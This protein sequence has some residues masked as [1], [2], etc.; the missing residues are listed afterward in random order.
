LSKPKFFVGLWTLLSAN[1]AQPD[2]KPTAHA[3]KVK[4]DLIRLI[5]IHANYNRDDVKNKQ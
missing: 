4:Q 2:D 1:V 3:Q 5:E